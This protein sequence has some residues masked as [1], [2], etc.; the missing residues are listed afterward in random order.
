MLKL[1]TSSISVESAYVFIFTNLRQ[2]QLE[3]NK[4]VWV[5]VS[6]YFSRWQKS[7][8]I[9]SFNIALELIFISIQ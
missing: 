2:F 3:T 6:D 7:L 4:F 1:S 5:H 9:I 8:Q